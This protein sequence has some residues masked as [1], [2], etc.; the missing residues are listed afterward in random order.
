MILVPLMGQKE[1]SGSVYLPDLGMVIDSQPDTTNS[2]NLL[3]QKQATSAAYMESTKE[4]R[5]MLQQLSGQ[6]EGLESSLDEDMAA[7]SL[8]NNRLRSLIGRMQAD[9]EMERANSAL[10]HAPVT[11]PEPMEQAA[12]SPA[13]F[14]AV[15]MGAVLTAYVGGRYSEV[16]RLCSGID[17]AELPASTATQ[18]AYWCAEANFRLGHFDA[19]IM[20][21]GGMR[22]NNHALKD[23]ALVLRGMIFMKQGK[24]ALARTQFETLIN[25]HPSSDYLRLAEMTLREI[26]VL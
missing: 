13:A 5:R 21:L 1:E 14:K 3:M 12:A 8:E 24:R 9:R 4:L 23:D 15:D 16:L 2:V 7:V 19:A 20:S 26:H 25:R 11:S 22:D 6:I 10:P 17:A 18:L